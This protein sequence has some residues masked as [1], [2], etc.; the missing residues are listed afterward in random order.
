MLEGQN[1]DEEEAQEVR[2]GW[3]D[4]VP[5]LLIGTSKRELTLLCTTTL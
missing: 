3:T 4:Q 1:D 5:E 2:P